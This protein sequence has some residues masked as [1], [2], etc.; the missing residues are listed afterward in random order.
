M[1]NFFRSIITA[2]LLGL[3]LF[4][5]AQTS[6]V[7]STNLVAG[8][9]FTIL[10]GGKYV[11]TSVL[12]INTNAATVSTLS[13]YD[14][15]NHS[16][17]NIQASYVSYA[18]VSTNWSNVFT[19]ADG[20]IVTNTFTGV[21]NVGTTVAAATNTLPSKLTFLVPAASSRTVNTVW[22][23]MLGATVNASAAGVIEIGYRQF[24][25]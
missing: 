2:A 13:F 15:Q 16:T 7:V 25:Q 24:T 20:L 9:P 23:P 6:L 18:T 17:T 1:K 11:I 19:N 10:S 4:A 8:T 14:S 12:F 3:G 21:S 22:Q 5:Q